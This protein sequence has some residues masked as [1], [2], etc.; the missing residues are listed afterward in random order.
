MSTISMCAEFFW[1]LSRGFSGC[2]LR[3]VF[4]SVWCFGG[5]LV[6]ACILVSVKFHVAKREVRML[7]GWNSVPETNAR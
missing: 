1:G 5:C 6:C 7:I 2:V 3:W 4:V